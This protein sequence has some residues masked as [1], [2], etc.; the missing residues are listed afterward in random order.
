MWCPRGLLVASQRNPCNRPRNGCSSSKSQTQRCVTVNE[1]GGPRSSIAVSSSKSL[2]LSLG[3][4]AGR[5]CGRGRACSWTGGPGSRR[6][7]PQLLCIDASSR[8][9]SPLGAGRRALPARRGPEHGAEGSAAQVPAGSCRRLGALLDGAARAEPSRSLPR[10]AGSP[11]QLAAR[12][13]RARIPTRSPRLGS[14]FLPGAVRRAPVPRE[15]GEGGGANAGAGSR[16]PVAR[17]QISSPD[18]PRKH[19]GR[20]ARGDVRETAAA[21]ASGR[22]CSEGRPRRAS[23]PSDPS[24][25]PP[26]PRPQRD[27]RGG[28]ASCREPRARHRP[29]VR[30]PAQAAMTRRPRRPRGAGLAVC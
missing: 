23:R 21:P 8:W 14:A 7:A 17:A 13:R 18:F 29:P 24:P 11:V 6:R 5:P 20:G 2:P 3:R 9:R 28:R 15:S 4:L 25:R 10:R 16:L 19:G 30:L 12:G 22:A 26:S 1:A 27:R